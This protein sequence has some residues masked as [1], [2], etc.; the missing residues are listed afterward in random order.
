MPLRSHLLGTDA[1]ECVATASPAESQS[2][3]AGNSDQCREPAPHRSWYALRL[4]SNREFAVRAAL[5]GYSIE[6]FLPTWWETVQWSD[7]TKTTERV[8]FPGYVFVRMSDGPE[9]YRALMTRGVVQIL[10]NYY[11][12]EPIDA[13]EIESVRRVVESKANIVPCLFTAGE[14]VTIDSGSLAGVTGVIVRTR[15]A[16]RVV[17]SIEILRRSVSVELDAD[18]LIRVQEGTTC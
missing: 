16:M 17:V 8:L 2:G 7:R 6:T 14:R 12:P 13:G 18:T 9:F 11:N 10:P 3:A 15:G 4:K 1:T 5:E